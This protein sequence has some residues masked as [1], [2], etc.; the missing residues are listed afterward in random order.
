M[1]FAKFALLALPILLGSSAAFSGS[2]GEDRVW[3]T[4]PDG[5]LQ[6]DEKIEGT[7][8]DPVVKA[9]EELAKKGVHILEAKKAND[10]KMRAQMCGMTTGN[11]TRFLVP[12]K[13]LTKA[14]AL[15]FEA[16]R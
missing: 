2:K 13:D 8:L 4:R 6:C 16:I 9:K 1:S 3:I 5:S 14:K 12:K 10:G 11:E 15:G 7:A